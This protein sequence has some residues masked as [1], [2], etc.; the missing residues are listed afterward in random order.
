MCER[1]HGGVRAPARALE[2]D[3]F[4]D[5]DPED[6]DRISISGR[7]H[8]TAWYLDGEDQASLQ[9]T[10]ELS[11]ETF[12]SADSPDLNE[13]NLSWAYTS[14]EVEN[15]PELLPE[16][17]EQP[18]DSHWN[19][20]RLWYFPETSDDGSHW[21]A[22]GHGLKMLGVF[23]DGNV[24]ARVYL[25]KTGNEE[26]GTPA[27]EPYAEQMNSLAD[28]VFEQLSTDDGYEPDE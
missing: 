11:R 5:A 1:G 16:P 17:V 18:V 27:P 15:S 10:L 2:D 28:Q 23:A 24:L 4:S 20:G 26:P 6:D 3:D 9:I 22:G 25:W 12:G 13:H 8:C 21:D 14:D 19:S 7:T